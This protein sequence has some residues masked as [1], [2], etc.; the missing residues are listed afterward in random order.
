MFGVDN[1]VSW[2]DYE[3]V[4]GFGSATQQD[5]NDLN[6]ALLA[7]QSQDIPAAVT[8][9]D[10]FALRVE[11][12]EQ[13]LRNTTYK[14]SAVRFWRNIPKLPAYNTV[15]EVNIISSYGANPDAGW[16]SEG[17]LPNEDDSTYE[18]QVAIVKYLGTT[19]R[20]SH[21][22]SMVK[23]AHGNVIAQETVNGTMHLLKILE[24]GL[25]YADHNLQSL[26]F[27]GFE[28][29]MLDNCPATNII[30]RRGL[31]LSEDVLT[32]ICLT[33]SDAPNYGQI[34]DVYMNPKVQADL[35]KTFFPK[36]RHDT[37]QKVGDFVGLD[38]KG[39]TSSSGDVR[40]Q[41]DTF[42][43]QGLRGP[44]AAA[45]GKAATRPGTPIVSTAATTPPAALSQFG[46]DDVGSYWLKVVAVN[47]YGKSIPVDVGGG[48]AIAAV[49]AGDEIT[50]AMTPGGATEVDFYEIYRSAVNG[51][52]GSEKL[53]L[54]TANAAGA[55]A[56]TLH[57]YNANLPNTSSV[58]CFQQNLE[59]MSFKQLAPMIKIS[60]GTIDSSIRWMQL[61]YGVPVLYAGGKV[62]LVRNVGR[63]AGYVGAP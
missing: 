18:R 31:P 22:M 28:R 36:E 14:M 17:D 3:G 43:D 10:G 35:T 40:F 6:K 30:D 1:M 56:Q 4:E 37:F 48:A 63:A 21:V 62:V 51:A 25:F 52:D 16:I 60:L 7:G 57:D 47:R 32:D 33:A 53:I 42:I 11:S 20:V 39:F 15:E 58:F 54:R 13:T 27:D 55:G 26:Q 8:A 46:A 2:K 59:A 41:P 61:L 29:L 12:L 49:I 44:N 23:P 45:V 9:G 5:V 38:I 50:W 19:R 24:R 34:T